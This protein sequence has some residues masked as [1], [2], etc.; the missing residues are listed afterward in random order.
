MCVRKQNNN[1]N[2]MPKPKPKK[3]KPLD[4]QTLAKKA[5]KAD[6]TIRSSA[7]EYLTFNQ[8]PIQPARCAMYA[9]NTFAAC[10]LLALS[11]AGCGR[12][13]TLTPTASTTT[14]PT[15]QEIATSAN[16]NTT[17]APPAPPQKAEYRRISAS[18]AKA[19]LDANASAILLDVRTG[20]EFRSQRIPGAILLPYDEIAAKAP[21]MLPDK[22]ALILIYCRSGNRSRTAARTLVSMGYTNTR[23]FGGI[24]DWP[25]ATEKN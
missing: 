3:T 10:L 7:A 1:F 4:P 2:P 15:R 16:N 21:A 12:Q 25:H 9:I 18:E 22:N 6:A 11:L 17:P 13:N 23:D 20:S 5:K 24:I 8:S 14:A 19:I